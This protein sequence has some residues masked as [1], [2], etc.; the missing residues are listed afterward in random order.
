MAGDTRFPAIDPSSW[1]E[2]GREEADGYAFVS[3]VRAGP[4]R[5]LG[6]LLAS[7][8]PV[9]H[10]GEYVFCSVPPASRDPGRGRAGGHGRGTGGD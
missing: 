3:Y 9:L 6:V 8:R 1:R 10:D 4:I 2:A 7:M 5:D